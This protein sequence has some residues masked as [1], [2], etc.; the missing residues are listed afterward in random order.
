MRIGYHIGILLSAVLLALSA[1]FAH[2]SEQVCAS[3]ENTVTNFYRWYL[4][5]ISSDNYP[6]TSAKHEDKENMARWISPSLL[7]TL[8]DE[9]SNN[10]LDAEYFTDAQDI[11][12]EWVSH[13]NS[14]K[15]TQTTREA[16]VELTLGVN[17]SKRKYEVV[18]DNNATC[19]KINRVQSVQ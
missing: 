16:R 3:P 19:W 12:D 11:F 5:E 1:S 10:E 17:E 14:H 18:V 8:Q 6:L 13:I 7:K 9:V 4:N 2:A 15:V